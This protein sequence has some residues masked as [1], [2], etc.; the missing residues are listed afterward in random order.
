MQQFIDAED[1]ALAHYGAVTVPK[2]AGKRYIVAA[3][4][5]NYEEVARIAAEVV[6]ESAGRF[7]STAGGPFS[8]S[9]TFDGSAAE[10]DFGF[11]CEYSRCMVPGA[12]L[13]TSFCDL[14]DQT[15]EESTAKWAKQIF[16]LPTTA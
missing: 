6:P 10:R 1:V 7:P 14:A 15:L 2:A 8:E 12:R 5:I 3:G 4:R 9:Y 11:K 16:S 13:L